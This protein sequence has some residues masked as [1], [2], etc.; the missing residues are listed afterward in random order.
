MWILGTVLALASLLVSAVAQDPNGSL[1]GEPLHG[2]YSTARA[3][4]FLYGDFDSDSMSAAW[5]PRHGPEL[6]P[7]WPDTIRVRILKEDAYSDGGVPRHVLV[8]WAR[9]DE[10]GAGQYSCHSCG[11]LIGIAVF[12]KDA[13]GWKVESANLE[14]AR[15]GAWGRP[16][17]IR[18]QRLGD[19]TWGIAALLSDM[20]E[21]ELE[22]QLRIFGPVAST[23]S[24]WY[25]AQLVDDGKYGEF[26]QDDWCKAR[27]G[28][29]EVI[30]AWRQI[31]YS[32]QADPGKPIYYLVRTRR[33]PSGLKRDVLRF[34]GKQFVKQPE[35]LAIRR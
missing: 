8:T 28:S 33:K 35:Q 4:E 14:L 29:N 23:F 1:A 27:G 11:V 6:D 9:P 24:T 22:Q 13:A 20:H 30:C 2:Q 5:T 18:L 10:E 31:D 16:P 17:Q 12:R 15:T 7:L 21:G 25:R 26:P 19:H 32:V 3:M 34:D